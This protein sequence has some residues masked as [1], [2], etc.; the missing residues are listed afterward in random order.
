MG[1][2]PSQFRHLSPEDRIIYKQWLRRGILFYGSLMAL[3]VFAAVANHIFT[4]VPSDVAG[5]PMHTAAISA[6][7]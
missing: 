2:L 4:A 5:E 1:P 7:K 6:R 3:L